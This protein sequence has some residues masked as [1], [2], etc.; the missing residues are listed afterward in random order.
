MDPIQ[1]EDGSM[2]I[3]IGPDPD[4]VPAE[5]AP[6]EH[7]DNL[8]EVLDDKVLAEISADCLEGYD[9]DIR[10]RD[11]WAR[12]YIKGLDL[13]GMKIEDRQEP[14]PGA[15]GVFHPILTESVIKFQAQAMS[16]L[17][18]AGGPVRTKIIA[19]MTKDVMELSQRI[20][21]EMNYL[22][23]EE[24]SEYRDETETMLFRLPLAGSAFKKIYYDPIEKR[25]CAMFVPAEDFVINYGASDLKTAIRYTHVMKKTEDQVAKIVDSGFW[26]DV[27]L[28]KPTNEKTDIQVKYDEMTGQTSAVTDDKRYTILETHVNYSIDGYD[29][30]GLS[31][32]YV[33]T[34]DKDSKEVLA[35]RRNWYAD[36]PNK[37][38][39]QA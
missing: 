3:E 10:S 5:V 12:S 17:F 32:P 23:T 28:G 27:E 24:M 20:E 15:S 4:P 26:R 16:E 14:W 33:V 8:A 31:S 37:R 2:D 9:I 39:E 35:I 6:G 18:P 19:K 29:T 36:D 30:D 7:D 13:M 11:E 1:N 22:L 34:I 25:P 21:T 38:K